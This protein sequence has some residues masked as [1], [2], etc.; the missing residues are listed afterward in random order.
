MTDK[1]IPATK[2]A[3]QQ[4]VLDAAKAAGATSLNLEDV[5]IVDAGRG[6]WDAAFAKHGAQLAQQS[7]GAVPGLQAVYRLAKTKAKTP[8]G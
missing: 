7:L 6:D 2:R 1:R 3:L 8:A 4:R 5:I